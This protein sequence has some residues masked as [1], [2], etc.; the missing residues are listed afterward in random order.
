MRFAVGRVAIE[1]GLWGL[2]GFA[3]VFFIIG[4]LLDRFVKNEKIRSGL[5]FGLGS[6]AAVIVFWYKD[7]VRLG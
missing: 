7:F 6:V 3:V 2:L 5:F 4:F 1:F